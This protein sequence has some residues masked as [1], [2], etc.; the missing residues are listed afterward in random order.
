MLYALKA[1][2]QKFAENFAHSSLTANHATVLGAVFVGLTMWSFWSGFYWLVPIFLLFRLIMNALDGLLARAQGTA[3]AAGEIMNELS[4]VLGD[5]LSY[6][7]LYFLFPE[8]QTAVLCF[9]FAIWCCEFI[10]VMG[11][12]LPNGRRRQES[13]GGG[14]P[15]RAVWMGLF[16]LALAF[17]PGILSYGVAFFSLLSLLVLLSAALRIRAAIRSAKNQSYTSDPQFGR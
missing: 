10:G 12:S 7:I 1:R 17:A 8:T 4:D 5:T 9:V 13:L 11:K 15:E 6:G 16:A 3:S 2:F 14:K